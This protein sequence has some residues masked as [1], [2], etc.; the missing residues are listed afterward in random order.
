MAD[1][2]AQARR[3][4]R[5]G[6]RLHRGHARRRAGAPR[7]CTP[8]TTTAWRCACRWRRSTARRRAAG[9]AGAHPRPALRRQDLPRLLRDPVRAWSQTPTGGDPGD[10]DRRPDRVRQGHAGGARSPTRSAT[11]CSIRARSTARPRWPRCGPA[12]PPTTRPRWRQLAGRLDLR[13]D[14][15]PH[16][17]RRRRRHRRAA[18]GGS[19]RA[20]VE[21]VGLAAGPRGAARAA[22]GVPP[23]AGSGRRR[24]RHG[25]GDLPRCRAEGLSHRERRAARRTAA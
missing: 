25:H 2:A 16:L 24:P 7:R 8:T 13:F 5:R 23:A 11:T 10:H 14:G 20:R 3:D 6:R 4:R 12:S 19:R 9:A 17:A 22:A 21:G 15:E 18:A 1:R